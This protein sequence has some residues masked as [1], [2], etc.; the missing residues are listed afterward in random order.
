MEGT[1]LPH[2]IFIVGSVVGRDVGSVYWGRYVVMDN[3]ISRIVY[4]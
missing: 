3:I 4:R 1:H 2:N